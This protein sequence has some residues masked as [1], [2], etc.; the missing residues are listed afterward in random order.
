VAFS[1]LICHPADE[2]YGA[3]RCGNFQPVLVAQVTMNENDEFE[4]LEIVTSW[5]G[6]WPSLHDAEILSVDFQRAD[7]SHSPG[8]SIKVHAFEMTSE[9]DKKAILSSLST[10]SSSSHS[11]KSTTLTSGILV[12]KMLSA[13]YRCPRRLQ[14]MVQGELLSSSNRLLEWNLAFLAQGL[15]LQG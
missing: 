13:E 9:V 2:C 6:Y 11:I 7:N 15:S 5:F 1:A 12:T 10:A 14:K 4:G 8:A 3:S